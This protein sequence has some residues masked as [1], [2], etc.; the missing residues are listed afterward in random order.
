MSRLTD[1]DVLT[2]S[3]RYPDRATSPHLTDAVRANVS[4]IARRVNALLEDLGWTGKVDV[5]SGFRPP[6]ANAAANG[7]TKSAHMVGQAVDLLDDKEQT[8]AKLIMSR[9]DLLIKHQLWLEHPDFTK[10]QRTNWAHIDFKQRRDRPV[11]VFNP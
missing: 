5:T 3:G 11:R 2:A 4:E 10:G 1:N 6:A 8:L 7:A 9:P